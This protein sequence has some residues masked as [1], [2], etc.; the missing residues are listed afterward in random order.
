MAVSELIQIHGIF[1]EI[2]IVIALGI[3]GTIWKYLS[4]IK[5]MH[6]EN[7]QAIEDLRKSVKIISGIFITY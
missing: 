2:I 7:Q 5:K 3:G 6:E 4:S 1:E